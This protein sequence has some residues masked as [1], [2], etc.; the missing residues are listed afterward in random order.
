[1][2]ESELLIGGILFFTGALAGFIDSIVGGGGLISLPAIMLTNLPIATCLGTNKLSSVF[3]SG[4]AMI[5][6]AKNGLVN[7]SF[8]KWIMPFTLIV[9]MA[10]AYIAVYVP[11]T[12]LKPVIIALLLVVLVIVVMKKDWGAISKVE[13]MHG[14]KL[15]AYMGTAI[16]IGLYDGFIGPG[17]GM[18]L[19]FYFLFMGYDF[20][21]ASGN[22]K[23]LNTVSNFG[24]LAVFMMMDQVHYGYG[25]AVAAG[26]IIGATTGSKLAMAKGAGLVRVLFI[27]M[28]LAMLLKLTYDYLLSQGI[29]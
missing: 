3:G 21:G 25:L 29:I 23:A 13:R 24:S 19:I 17:T 22:A 27:T 9:S 26:Q 16:I 15:L 11:P 6:F 2:M 1:M 7:W 20:L 14:W 12:F 4:T 28:S 5:N 8:L 10:G 18:F